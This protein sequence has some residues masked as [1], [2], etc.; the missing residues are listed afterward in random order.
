MRAFII[1]VFLQ[2]ISAQSMDVMTFN[3]RYDN[4]GDGIHRWDLRKAQVVETI[5]KRS[6]DIIGLQEVL[7]HQLMYLDSTMEYYTLIGSGRDDGQQ[8]GEYSPIAFRHD[9]FTNLGSGTLWLNDTI[10]APGIAWG[11]CC[12][13]IVS[14]VRL[15][16]ADGK[17]FLVLNTHWDH[18][19]ELA[20]ANSATVILNLIRTMAGDLPII[21][22]GD[23]NTIPDT[24]PIRLLKNVVDDSHSRSLT[25]PRGSFGTWSGFTKP[26]DG[27]TRIDYIFVRGFK[28]N[29]YETVM[30]NDSGR[31]PSDHLPVFITVDF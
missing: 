18:Q 23:F 14:W 26:G 11:A 6:P 5:L 31:Y 3:I 7:H 10:L 12:N 19:S 15:K 20:R 1:L 4:P 25:K 28:V 24:A 17:V 8:K 27:K 30:D 13:R 29:Q 9:R 2:T 16:A 22:T 21:L